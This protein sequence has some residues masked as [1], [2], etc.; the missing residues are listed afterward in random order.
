M[1]LGLKHLAVLTIAAVQ[2]VSLA[3]GRSDSSDATPTVVVRVAPVPTPTPV[4]PEA[5][6]KRSGE[7]M[8]GLRA[9]HFRL[10]H[11]TGGL[12]LLPGIVIEEVT[13]DVIK[14][15]KLSIKFSGAIGTGFA[16]RASLM[17]LGDESYMT[18]PLTGE[19]TAGPTG[20]SALGF[21]DPSRG[22]EAMMAQ[23]KDPSLLGKGADRRKVLRLGGRLPTEALAPLV[24]ET[25]EDSTV[26]VELIL[27]SE[28]LYLLEA[29]FA[30]PVTP[31]DSDDT[32]RVITISRFNEP[33]SI[34]AP[35]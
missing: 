31:T 35:L 33:I 23:V 25:L 20:V 19:W 27:D 5:V 2:L 18:D 10:Y 12:E 24:G 30:G 7:V 29:R 21:F 16:I 8:K 26:Q 9:F 28:H 34:E 6:L 1:S 15:D 11:E 17:T 32:V 4:N 14:P 22:I 3:C 13:G